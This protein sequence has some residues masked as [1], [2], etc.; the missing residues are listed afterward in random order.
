V[1][2]TSEGREGAGAGD[3]VVLKKEFRSDE[4]WL[5]ISLPG[6]LDPFGLKSIAWIMVLL[7]GAGSSVCCQLVWVERAQVFL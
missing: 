6:L 2:S 4:R 5:A 7:L 1:S 3:A